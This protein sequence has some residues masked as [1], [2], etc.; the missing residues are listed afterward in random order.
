MLFNGTDLILA[1]VTFAFLASLILA[2]GFIFRNI[3]VTLAET[4]S[5]Y[6]YN[7]FL[8]KK[9]I[10]EQIATYISIFFGLGFV[11]LTIMG[12]YMNL[13]NI[14]KESFFLGS[15]VNLILFFVVSFLFIFFICK[16]SDLIARNKYIPLLKEKLREGFDDSLFIY[17]HDGMQKQH[18]EKNAQLTRE[19]KDA[20]LK[21]AEERFERICLLLD[22]KIKKSKNYEE[23]IE[24]LK[25]KFTMAKVSFL[26]KF[27]YLVLLLIQPNKLVKIDRDCNLKMEFETNEGFKVQK[28]NKTFIDKQLKDFEHHSC[29]SINATRMAL[30]KSFATSLLILLLAFGIF[31]FRNHSVSKLQLLY[32]NEIISAFIFLAVG[33]FRLGR[34]IETWGGG[35]N[36][37]NIE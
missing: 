6:G 33:L 2:K 14:G 4:A 35:Y 17:T 27:F 20:N 37:G 12:T 26:N 15:K 18:I 3:S 30:G 32:S 9:S 10:T 34:E 28:D 7:P 29:E 13:H 8:I 5:Y 24:S 11:I 16:I 22:I 1:G 19:Q 21:L 31:Y 36:T 23:I 25:A